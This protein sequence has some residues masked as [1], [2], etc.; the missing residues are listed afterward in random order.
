M[1]TKN[2][3]IRNLTIQSAIQRDISLHVRKVESKKIYRRSREAQ[4]S[5]GCY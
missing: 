5:R 2:I 3:S 4:I 1:K